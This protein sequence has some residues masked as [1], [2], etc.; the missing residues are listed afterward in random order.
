MVN[1]TY[2][3]A[4]SAMKSKGHDTPFYEG[5]CDIG[6]AMDNFHQDRKK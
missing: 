6:W 3:I 5:I 4:N 1:Y 2:K